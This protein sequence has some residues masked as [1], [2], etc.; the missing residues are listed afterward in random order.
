LLLNALSFVDNNI[1]SL[2]NEWFRKLQESTSLH[3]LKVHVSFK[4]S[5]LVWKAVFKEQLI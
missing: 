2:D 5:L 3:I 1:K 4:P